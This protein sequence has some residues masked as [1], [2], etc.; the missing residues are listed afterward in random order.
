MGAGREFMLASARNRGLESLAPGRLQSLVRKRD[1]GLARIVP[2]PGL[3]PHHDQRSSCQG[4]RLIDREPGSLVVRTDV[5][6]GVEEDPTGKIALG[7]VRPV[8]WCG[9]REMPAVFA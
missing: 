2:V 1:E 8:L 9:R 5:A 4:K 6:V 7:R 3:R